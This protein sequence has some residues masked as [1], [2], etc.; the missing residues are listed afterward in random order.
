MWFSAIKLAL[1]AGTHIFMQKRQ[2]AKMAMADAQHM[3]AERRWP[4]V[5]KLTRA[6]L[7]EARHKDY[8]DEVVL[9]ILTLP[10]IIVGLRGLVR[11][12]GGHGQDK[13]LLRAFRGTSDMV[14]KFMDTCMRQH[15]WYK[16]N[17]NI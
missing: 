2:K 17:T 14:Y 11:R 7:L 3:H 5:R 8:K 15:I 6:N 4:E 12:S 13:N 10:I 9:A 16:G 1:Q